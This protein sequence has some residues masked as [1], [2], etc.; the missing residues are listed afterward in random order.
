MHGAIGITKAGW[1]R[2]R[3]ASLPSRTSRYDRKPPSGTPA[4]SRVLPKWIMHPMPDVRFGGVVPAWRF[5]QV[6]P[7]VKVSWSRQ[8]AAARAQ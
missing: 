3:F 8:Q 1:R 7:Y 2:Q 5:L 6:A 4:A